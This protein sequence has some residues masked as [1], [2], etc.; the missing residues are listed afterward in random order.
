MF[1]M[2]T[3]GLPRN[4]RELKEYFYESPGDIED[5]AACAAVLGGVIGVAAAG[6]MPV[7]KDR[8][9]PGRIAQKM[10]QVARTT[11][12]GTVAGAAV[13]AAGLAYLRAAPVTVPLTYAFFKYYDMKYERQKSIDNIV[14]QNVELKHTI[15]ELKK[16]R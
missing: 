5:R 16:L 1:R 15:N 12:I 11:I 6:F 4:S 8:T 3:R 7:D 10:E 13:G 9:K 14:S 2:F